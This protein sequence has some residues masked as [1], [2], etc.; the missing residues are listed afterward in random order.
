[1]IIFEPAF[2]ERQ[3]HFFY[4]RQPM[5][6]TYVYIITLAGRYKAKTNTKI[7]ESSFILFF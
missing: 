2:L 4:W 7:Y 1:M 3:V 5:L 6:N